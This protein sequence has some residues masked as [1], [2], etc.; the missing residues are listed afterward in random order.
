M[1]KFEDY[2]DLT[3]FLYWE[4]DIPNQDLL[5]NEKMKITDIGIVKKWL[6]IASEILKNNTDFNS[7]DDVKDI[8]IE[9]IKE[10]EMKNGQVLW[11][12]RVALSWEMFSP[13]ALELIFIL[14]NKKSSER[15]E[16]VLKELS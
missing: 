16:K 6:S 14:W 2:E 10:A 5:L 11:P 8:F 15:I 3:L 12:V 1:K 7:V 9:K 13:W 4:Y